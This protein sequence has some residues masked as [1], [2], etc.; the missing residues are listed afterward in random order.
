MLSS[1]EFMGCVGQRLHKQHVYVPNILMRE[2]CNPA[3]VC[4]KF[5][6]GIAWPG[7]G[8]PWLGVCIGSNRRV[9]MQDSTLVLAIALMPILGLPARV[10]LRTL[11]TGQTLNICLAPVTASQSGVVGLAFP[12]SPVARAP[13]C[14]YAP[15]SLAHLLFLTPATVLWVLRHQLWA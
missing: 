10:T 12:A 11:S 2:E 6:G 9:G 14:P 13:Q 15:I 1:F 7:L 8:P 4:S 3:G 5:P